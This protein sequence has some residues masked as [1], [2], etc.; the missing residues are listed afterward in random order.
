MNEFQLIDFITKDF[1]VYKPNL[2]KGIGDDCAVWTENGSIRVFTTDTMVEGDHFKKDWMSAEQI[3][4]R[5][6][7]INISDI[8]AMGAMPDLLF[9]SL[10]VDDN[11]SSEWLKLLYQGIKETCLN[12]QVTLAGGNITHGQTLSLNVGIF[13][14]SDDA[15]V[16]R[17]GAKTNDLLC[18]TG[19]IGSACCA[20]LLLAKNKKVPA[21]LLSAF[22]APK[23]RLLEAQV[24]K[25]YA[26]SMIDVSDGLAGESRHLAKE[27]GLGVL[28]NSSDIPYHIDALEIESQ[29][30]VSLMDCALRGGE[31]FELMFSVS[32]NDYD[33]LKKEYKF[34]SPITVIG[35]FLPE[36][37]YQYSV[38][39]KILDLPKGFD[40]FSD[41]INL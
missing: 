24:I 22:V 26:T 38:N 29:L 20:R 30:D 2:I 40:H 5:L 13:G 1:P 33:K 39:E 28:I 19:N 21:D 4:K 15:V 10:V 9:V 16:Y 6:I 31:D 35:K 37:K 27:S 23:A 32:Q 36:K 14:N 18:V 3:G 12:Y 41:N 25:K 34:K 7:E 17:S 8:V 11:T